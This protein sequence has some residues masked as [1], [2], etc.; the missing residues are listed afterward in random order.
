MQLIY[1]LDSVY[2]VGLVAPQIKISFDTSGALGGANVGGTCRMWPEE[3]IVTISLT[4]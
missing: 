3:P 2:T 1:K 4:E